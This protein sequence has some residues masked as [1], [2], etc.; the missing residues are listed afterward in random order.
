[1][2]AGFF[3][4]IRRRLKIVQKGYISIP[5]YI[6]FLHWD[7]G[8]TFLNKIKSLNIVGFIKE[9]KNTTDKVIIKTPFKNVKIELLNQKLKQTDTNKG[10]IIKDPVLIKNNQ[11]LI[12]Q[13]TEKNFTLLTKDELKELIKAYNMLYNEIIGYDKEFIKTKEDKFLSFINENIKDPLLKEVLNYFF[14]IKG[15]NEQNIRYWDA[16]KKSPLGLI[17]HFDYEGALLVHTLSVSKSV[18]TLCK[19]YN[20]PEKEKEFAIFCSLLHDIGKIKSYTQNNKKTTISTEGLLG[21]ITIGITEIQKAFFS[22]I[23][24]TQDI[25]TKNKLNLLFLLTASHIQTH[26]ESLNLKPATKTA[27]IL[28]IA[29]KLDAELPFAQEEIGTFKGKTIA[30]LNLLQQVILNL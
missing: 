24:K 30:S 26:H 7:Y 2:S 10:F 14:P 23:D 9:V 4:I 13:T 11:Y 18:L 27:L 28:Q 6:K 15:V 8:N 20:I 29:D 17:R 1:M 19:T 25:D 16:F 5:T 21:H 3:L 12:L 22:V